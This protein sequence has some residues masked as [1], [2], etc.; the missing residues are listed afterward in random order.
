MQKR[1]LLANWV[2]ENEMMNPRQGVGS[3][4]IK[5]ETP[6][7]AIQARCLTFA[8]QLKGVFWTVDSVT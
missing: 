3:D 1:L 2:S 7:R 6:P 8:M 5:E 4:S